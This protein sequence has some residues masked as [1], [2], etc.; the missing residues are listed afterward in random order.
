VER[1]SLREDKRIG[2]V[3]KASAPKIGVRAETE[4]QEIF[5]SDGPLSVTDVLGTASGAL[6]VGLTDYLSNDE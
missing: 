2:K 3:S 1:R 5:Y 6:P 4:G